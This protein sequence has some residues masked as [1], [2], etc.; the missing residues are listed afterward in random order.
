MTARELRVWTPAADQVLIAAHQRGATLQAIADEVGDGCTLSHAKSR[1][2]ALQRA[3]VLE[4]RKPR[5]TASKRD[6]LAQLKRDGHSLRELE[7]E[8]AVTR[9]TITRQL[10]TLRRLG[11]DLSLSDKG[12]RRHR[13]RGY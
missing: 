9:G 10:A 5:W 2:A 1:V 12:H 13:L 11:Y 8:F 3:G 6:R 7:Q 4:A